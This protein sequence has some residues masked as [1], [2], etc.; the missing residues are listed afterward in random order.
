MGLSNSYVFK[1]GASGSEAEIAG[2]LDGTMTMNGS[3]VD[4]TN[5]ANGGNI[6]Y[7]PDFVAG[8]QISW[9][10]TFTAADNVQLNT[11][12]AAIEAGTLVAGN[13]VSG[14]GAEEWQCD[15]WSIS[16]RS[17]TASVNGVTQLA[18]TFNTSGSYT[19]T[20]SS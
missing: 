10:V 15:T 20:P 18:C 7:Y 3:P 5:K 2:Q 4:V 12:K 19:Y 8:K 14:D 16:G 9:A 17:D 1:I 11:I 13:I 6:E